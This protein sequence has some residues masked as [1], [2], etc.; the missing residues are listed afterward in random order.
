MPLL[1][2]GPLTFIL[3]SGASG[4]PLNGCARVI[5][6]GGVFAT[7]EAARDAAERAKSAIIQWAVK[8]RAGVD[9]GDGLKRAASTEDGIRY[10]EA[11]FGRPVRDD[12]HGID[13]F[14]SGPDYGFL[15]H[16]LKETV[17]KN[18][19][20]F[21]A[22]FQE[23]F[24]SAHKITTKQA[25]AGEIY[26]SSFFDVGQRSRF[27]TLVTAIEA[28]IECRPREGEARALVNQFE[29]MTKESGLDNSI[30]QSL[31][32]AL[33]WLR[34]ESIGHAG[35]ALAERLLAGQTFSGVLPG[36]F[37][38][39]AYDLR[40]ELMHTGATSAETDMLAKSNAMEEFANSLI[41]ASLLAH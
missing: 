7:Q 4:L 33:N 39:L 30:R 27:I 37:F 34:S 2:D 6:T 25:L 5:V 13:V 41:R 19:D 12:I 40:G 23:G 22:A 17:E 31:L 3:R 35:K 38:S 1:Q 18:A 14:E 29:L 28:L 24:G 9:F 20:N 10:W 32:G 26:A 36:K 8:E 16:D 15:Y 21:I 11:Q